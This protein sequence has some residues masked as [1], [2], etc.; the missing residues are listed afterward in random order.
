MRYTKSADWYQVSQITG[1]THNLLRIQF[2]P[3][4]EVGPVHAERFVL[5]REA[6]ISPL[7]E[8][9]IVRTVIAAVAAEQLE[10][11]QPLHVKLIG[12]VP[13]D[14]GPEER[15]E[16]FARAIVRRLLDGLPFEATVPAEDSKPG[17]AGRRT[18]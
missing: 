16:R 11:E 7:D 13:S 1:P 12:Y 8:N 6:H 18:Q 3:R 17:P 4:G 15:Y 14:T 2:Y 9:A 5:P 10:C